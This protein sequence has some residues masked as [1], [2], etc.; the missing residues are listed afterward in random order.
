MYLRKHSCPLPFLIQ[1][2]PF[3]GEGLGSRDGA[4]NGNILNIV[5]LEALSSLPTVH[6]ME[7]SMDQQ[8]V[9]ESD[10]KFVT[11]SELLLERFKVQPLVSLD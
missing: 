8:M 10:Q 7:R 6:W 4:A 1:I 3:D 11:W 5:A 9:T 2:L